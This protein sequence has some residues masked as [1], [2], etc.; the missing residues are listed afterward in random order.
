M[1]I[2][3]GTSDKEDGNVRVV[4]WVLVPGKKTKYC[5]HFRTY[6]SILEFRNHVQIPG[7]KNTGSI[8]LLHPVVAIL[9]QEA[10]A[11]VFEYRHAARVR[12]VRLLTL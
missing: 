10:H 9:L 2:I 12:V 6:W 3:N 11:D 8:Y 7:E 4:F 1:K 5:V